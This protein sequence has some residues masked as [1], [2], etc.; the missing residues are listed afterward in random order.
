MGGDRTARFAHYHRMRDVARI[1]YALDA[2]YHVARIFIER[3][4][5]RRL[6]VGAAAVIVD[7]QAAADVDVLEAGAHDLEFGIDMRQLIDRVLYPPDVLQLAAWMAVHQ[8]QTV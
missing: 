3:V 8:L 7:A 4:V 2:I 1:A 6:V 5:H